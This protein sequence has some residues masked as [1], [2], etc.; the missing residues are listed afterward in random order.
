MFMKILCIFSAR[1]AYF[2][3]FPG[4]MPNEFEVFPQLL[5][6]LQNAKLTFSILIGRYIPNA[7]YEIFNFYIKGPK[8]RQIYFPQDPFI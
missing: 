4:I 1:E 3:T 6:Y 8:R 2:Q 7:K 5:L